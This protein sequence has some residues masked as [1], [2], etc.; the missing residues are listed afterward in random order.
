[1]VPVETPA[2]AKEVTGAWGK[3]ELLTP[4][5]PPTVPAFMALDTL[6]PPR[7]KEYP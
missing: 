5:M 4:T 1:M 7:K 2:D 3:V 6:T